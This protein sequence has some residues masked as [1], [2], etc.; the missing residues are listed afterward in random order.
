MMGRHSYPRFSTFPMSEQAAEL[1]G[2]W[3]AAQKELLMKQNAFEFAMKQ[4]KHD[5]VQER[6]LQL[7]EQIAKEKEAADQ[8][9]R[10]QREEFEQRLLALKA[11]AAEADES[12]PLRLTNRQRHVTLKAIGKWKAF[13]HMSLKQELV[14]AAILL[15]E[16]NAICV[17]LG[18]NIIFQ[19]ML[20][21]EGPYSPTED[22]ETK[23]VVEIVNK[24]TAD[25]VALWPLQKLRYG[26]ASPP[27]R[28]PSLFCCCC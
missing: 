13:R 12:E 28:C 4:E 22:P 17:E 26:M 14:S 20:R 18:K 1:P 24:E 15:K 10:Q 8:L 3:A 19:F 2:D 11:S 21:S 5:E 25:R 16:A 6:L 27:C 7:E 23:I 9:L